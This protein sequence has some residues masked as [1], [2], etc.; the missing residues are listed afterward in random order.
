MPRLHVM[1]SSHDDA[2]FSKVSP[3][4][5][6]VINGTKAL[7]DLWSGNTYS[8]LYNLAMESGTTKAHYELAWD[9]PC[10]F[11]V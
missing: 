11:P 2:Q 10:S 1:Q 3:P 6:T 8:P 5:R 7:R 9:A 4:T